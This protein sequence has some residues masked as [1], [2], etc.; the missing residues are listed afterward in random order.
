MWCHSMFFDRYFA[1]GKIDKVQLADY[2]QRR[3]T[4]I[5]ELQKYLSKNIE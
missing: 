4:T 2:A 5:A 3:G 1:V